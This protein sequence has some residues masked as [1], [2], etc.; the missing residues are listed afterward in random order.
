[1]VK[2][3]DYIVAF[4]VKD[5]ITNVT[6]EQAGI[7][8]HSEPGVGSRGYSFPVKNYSADEK[9]FVQPYNIYAEDECLMLVSPAE[10]IIPGKPPNY[11][12]EPLEQ[13]EKGVILECSQGPPRNL[14][15]TVHEDGSRTFNGWFLPGSMNEM[16]F[17]VELRKATEGVEIVASRS[18]RC[19]LLDS[20]GN[21]YMDSFGG[22]SVRLPISPNNREGFGKAGDVLV[23]GFQIAVGDSYSYNPNVVPTPQT[24]R[25]KITGGTVGR[26]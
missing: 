26:Y 9:I 18:I 19:M 12:P 2:I 8:V 22:G 5:S 13:W 6:V 3:G 14:G 15:W 20:L 25:G 1:M 10:G 7:Q 21:W 23:V 16:W 17:Q 24:A 11:F 4:V